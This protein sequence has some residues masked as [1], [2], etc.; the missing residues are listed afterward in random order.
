M[1]RRNESPALRAVSA[2][3]LGKDGQSDDWLCSENGG[4]QDLQLGAGSA[5]P[6]V[7]QSTSARHLVLTARP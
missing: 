1:G 7:L 3:V 6:H 5:G 4:E 2:Y